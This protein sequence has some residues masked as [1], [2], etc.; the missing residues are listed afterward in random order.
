VQWKNA[1]SVC[2][3]AASKGY[4]GHYEVGYPINGLNNIQDAFIFHAGTKI[5]IKKATC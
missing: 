5:R 4:P 2:V 1:K 3:V